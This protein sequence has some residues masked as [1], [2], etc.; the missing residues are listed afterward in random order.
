MARTKLALAN[1]A[2]GHLVRDTLSSIDGTSPASVQVRENMSNATERVIEEFDWPFCRVVTSATEVSGVVPRGW[3][4]VYAYP[5]DC[6]KLWHLGNERNKETAPFEI[7]L[8]PDP[9][10]DSMYIFTD[11]AGA[12]IRYGSNRV[13]IERFSPGAFDLV[14]LAL[15]DICCM[16]LTKDRRL[17]DSIN[18][19]YYRRLSKVQTSYAN[20]EP[21]V[22]DNDF[23]PEAIQVRSS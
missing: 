17:K 7:G 23:I 12:A 6:V 18:A 15:A 16:A 4:F 5:A 1:A 11:F 14:A 19:E 10:N 20:L 22:L 21:E 9:T 13:P 2:L 3:T 8:S